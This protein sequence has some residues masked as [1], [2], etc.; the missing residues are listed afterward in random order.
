MLIAGLLVCAVAIVGAFEFRGHE[1]W[2]AVVRHR[3]VGTVAAFGLIGLVPLMVTT[4]ASAAIVPTVAL[5]T[6]GN[7]A[8]LAGS[9]V[10]N[11]GASALGGSLGLWP[12]TSITG[13]PPGLVTPPGTTDNAN[14]AAQQAESDLTAAYV[15]AAGRP[16]DAT[17]TADLANL[18]LGAGVYAGPNHSPLGLTGPLVLDGAGDPTSVFIFQTDSSLTTASSSTVTMINGAQECNVFWQVG[19]SATLG[20]GSVFRGNILALT[21]IT[22]TNSVTVHGR[23]LARNGAVTLDN[24][25]FTSPTC[26]QAV[27]ATTTTTTPGA[28][29]TTVPGATTTA[30]GET[31][32]PPGATTTVPEATTT[33]PGGQVTTTSPSGSTSTTV[34]TPS[35]TPPTS[36]RIT[37]TST[38]A[39]PGLPPTGAAIA[40][41]VM[42]AILALGCGAFVV[43]N[44][45]RSEAV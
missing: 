27:P 16:I 29:T 35:T 12:G 45:R 36:E 18:M 15:D 7:Y 22:V 23:A 40:T 17:T 24:D 30:P 28:T 19:S 5:A 9:T 11:T 42:V 21:S 34:M 44:A 2:R 10:T 43:R 25:T 14:A 1:S 33:T 26:A 41:E 6:S 37:L 31:P 20:T 8:V 4:A 32:R 39:G 13:F 38:T 3:P